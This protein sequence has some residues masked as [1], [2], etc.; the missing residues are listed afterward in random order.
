MSSYIHKSYDELKNMLESL[1]FQNHINNLTKKYKNKKIV[2]YGAGLLADVIF[3]NYD[4]SGLNI[5]SVADS[6]YVYEKESYRNYNTSSPDEI[7]ELNP[8]LILISILEDIKV[9]K[10]FQT[11]YPNLM[12]FKMKNI[13]NKG[14]VA[15][16]KAVLFGY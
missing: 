12:K 6:K 4:L 2:L 5:I 13:L 9:R 10:F 7:E 14:F 16:I 3:D 1:K 15:K 8:D 11:Y